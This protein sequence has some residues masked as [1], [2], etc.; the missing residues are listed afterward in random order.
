MADQGFKRM[1]DAI[2]SANV[3]GYS[4]LMGDNEKATSRTI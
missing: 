3:E 2:L 4:R 1:L